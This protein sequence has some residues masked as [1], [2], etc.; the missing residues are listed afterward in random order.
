ML[1]S[2]RRTGVVVVRADSGLGKSTAGKVSRQ[3]LMYLERF[4]RMT[5]SAEH[6]LVNAVAA[7]MRPDES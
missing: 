5:P 3:L 7:A 6:L 1:V 4:T 2:C